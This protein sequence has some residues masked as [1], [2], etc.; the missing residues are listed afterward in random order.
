MKMTWWCPSWPPSGADGGDDMAQFQTLSGRL[1]STLTWLLRR[2]GHA[3]W[4]AIGGLAVVAALGAAAQGLP[5]RSDEPGMGPL[6]Q[7]GTASSPGAPRPGTTSAGVDSD[8]ENSGTSGD[9]DR[10]SRDQDSGDLTTPVTPGT[11]AST[12]DPD[13]QRQDRDGA[14]DANHDQPAQVPDTED[15]GGGQD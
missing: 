9:L 7:V 11:G 10:D 2:P 8:Q 12:T 6:V 3:I 1:K 5:G 15:A 13:D 4:A 14:A